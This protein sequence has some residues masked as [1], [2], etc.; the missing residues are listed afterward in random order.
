M[1]R[2]TGRVFTD[3]SIWMA[4]FGLAIGLLFPPFCLLLGLPADR[5]LSPA[6]FVSTVVAGVL[7][8]GVNFALARVVVG[9]RLRRLAESMSRVEVQLAAATRSGD[10]S[11]CDP[12]ACSLPVDSADEVGSSAAAF[13]S[14][15]TTLARSHAIESATRTFTQ[16][17]AAH[18]DLDTLARAA[19]DSVLADTASNAGLLAVERDDGLEPLASVGIRDA[20]QVAGNAQ[21]AQVLRAGRIA[22][23]DV[24][25]ERV[26]VDSVLLE[27]LA[28]SVLIVPLAFKSVPLGVLILATVDSFAPD[29][30]ILLEHVATDLG[31]ALSNALSHDRLQRLAALDPLTDAYNRRF[32][33]GRLQEEFGRAV[34]T[35]SPLGVLMVDLDHFKV[36]NDTHGHLIGDRV[37]RAAAA[38]IR[39]VIREGDVLVR[40]GGEEFLVLLPGAG[41]TD[42][43]ETAER[44]RRSV[45]A[46]VVG[47]GDRRVT[48]TASVGGATYPEHDVGSATDL[49]D[50]ADVALYAAKEAGRDRV[51]IG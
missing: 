28:R 13:N 12:I 8:G 27:Q 1:P 3:L 51:A 19:L 10:W 50:V 33:A 44:V 42:L 47:D 49:V 18:L 24:D 4:A 17:A 45:A 46:T 23:L 5:V 38:A 32:G 20:Q 11:G 30:D 14:L 43:A 39:R 37:L 2:L 41:R 6:F 21:V 48:V 35:G 34:R 40:Y 36:V 25:Q 15:I 7:V 9:T 31:L 22:R 16:V 26:V 29:V